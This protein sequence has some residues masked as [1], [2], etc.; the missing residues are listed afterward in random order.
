[1]LRP[2]GTATIIGMIP[3][4]TKI[5]LHGFHFLR[6][7]RIQGSSM[8]SNHLRVV[9]PRL[10]THAVAAGSAQTDNLISSRIRL[11]EINQGFA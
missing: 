4:G 8:R 11:D 6:E 9:M 2:G 7:R 5:E 3:F 1:M 10:L